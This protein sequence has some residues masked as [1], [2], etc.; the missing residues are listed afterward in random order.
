[1][2]DTTV[3]SVQVLTSAES[4]HLQDVSE[5]AVAALRVSR[6]V[7][8]TCG[9]APVMPLL[10]FQRIS[11]RRGEDYRGVTI[12]FRPVTDVWEQLVSHNEPR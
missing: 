10:R 9:G 4:A 8:L 1:M 2:S 12:G 3:N 7:V 6:C 5:I 11:E